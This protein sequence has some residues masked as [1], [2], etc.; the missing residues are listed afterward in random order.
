MSRYEITFKKSAA[1]ELE[2]IPKPHGPRILAA[3]IELADEPRPHGVKKL[4]GEDDRYRIRVGNYRAIYTI[5]DGEL[6][7]EVV[8]VAHRQGAY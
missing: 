8:R 4:K 3:I 5:D 7:V 1:R 2:R 6:I